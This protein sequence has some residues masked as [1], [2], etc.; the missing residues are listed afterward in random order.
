MAL[1]GVKKAS[2]NCKLSFSRVKFGVHGP[3]MLTQTAGSVRRPWPFSRQL[4]LFVIRHV[5]F[6]CY[7]Y[8]KISRKVTEVR[9]NFAVFPLMHRIA[10]SIYN[11]S[12]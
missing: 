9:A 4:P 8:L 10:L 3:C 7:I 12:Q 5:L 11:I 6:F 1:T 2:T